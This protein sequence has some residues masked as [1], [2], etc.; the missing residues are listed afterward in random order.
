MGPGTFLLNTRFLKLH[1]KQLEVFKNR[2]RFKVVVA[3]RRWGKCLAEGTAI[4]LA[5]GTRK[6]VEDIRPGD[7]LIT[8]NEDTYALEAKPVMHLMDNG[9][10][11]TLTITTRSGK[12]ITVTPNHPMLAN[13][14]WTDAGNLKIGDL[15]ATPKFGQ[16]GNKPMAD[17]EVDLLAIWLAEGRANQISNTTP[18]VLDALRASLDT[19]GC[20][21]EHIKGPDWRWVQEPRVRMSAASVFLKEQGVWG[22]DS[23]TKFIP[24]SVFA[25]PRPQLARFLNLFIACDGSINRRSKD[26]WAMEIGLSNERMVRQLADLFL[27]FG[28]RGNISKKVHKATSRMTGENFVSWRFIVSNRDSLTAFCEHVGALSKETAV[29][30]ALKSTRASAGSCNEYLPIR[31]EDFIQHLRYEPTQKGKFGGYNNLIARDL[32]EEL[33]AGLNGWRKQ[34]R[35][36]VSVRRYAALRKFS[37][38]FFDPIADGDVAWDEILTIEVSGPKP[39][40][41]LTMEG[42]HNFIAEGLVTHNTYL[43]RTALLVAA[44]GEKKRNIWYVA[45][46]YGM[47]KDIMWSDLVEAIPSRLIAK[48]NET[49]LEIRLVNGSVIQLKGADKADTLRGRGIHFVVLDEYQDFK[50]GTWEEVIYPTLIDTRGSALIIGT[51]KSFNGLY[52]LYMKGQDPAHKAEWASWQFPTISSP[53]IPAAEIEAARRNLTEKSFKQE[54]EASF[55]SMTGRIYY[56]FDRKVHVKELPP[57][58]PI[59]PIFVGQDF[60]VDPMTSVIFQ[61]WEDPKFPKRSLDRYVIHVK[62]EINLRSSNVVEVCDEL[63]RRYWRWIK[64]GRLALY[65]DPAGR[66]RNQGRGETNFQIFR[67]RGINN[68]Y[69]RLKHPAREDRYNAVN[70]MLQSAEGRVRMFVDPKCKTLIESF[71]KTIYKAGTSDVDKNGDVEHITD[72]LGYPVELLFPVKK[73]KIIGVSV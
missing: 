22:L 15:L 73:V 60:N 54:F 24:K 68:V 30:S 5:D 56:N 47:A 72:A 57:I 55:E 8:L 40:Y 31:Y 1:K 46:T 34:D 50:A 3:G 58:D 19:F 13:N 52:S 27:K 39:T 26:T 25:L 69:A 21:L 6:C 63:E 4:T 42:N 2:A 36:R 70:L 7:Y 35:S 18:E 53:F 44:C 64:A 48:K 12:R 16:F 9:V 29:E 67:E 28:I 65:P 32:P 49:K 38:G 51:P 61:L 43:S 66:N 59:K 17:H 14:V 11:E 20:Q 10:K 37:D 62:D 23:K 71:E 45:P 41:D 33:R